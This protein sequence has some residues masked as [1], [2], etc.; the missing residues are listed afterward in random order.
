MNDLNPQ[1]QLGQL[2]ATPDRLVVHHLNTLVVNG[3]YYNEDEDT[4]TVVLTLPTEN[5]TMIEIPDVPPGEAEMFVVGEE[6]RL[7]A[8]LER[9]V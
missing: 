8:A 4:F 3:K 9:G 1:P 7:D 6:W 2:A 5:G